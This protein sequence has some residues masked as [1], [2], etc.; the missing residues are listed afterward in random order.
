[1]LLESSYI[2]GGDANG[3]IILENNLAIP[4][5]FIHRVTM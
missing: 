5:N 3:P 4:Q 1:M 2:V